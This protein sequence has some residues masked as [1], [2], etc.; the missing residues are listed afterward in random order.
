MDEPKVYIVPSEIV[1][2]PYPYLGFVVGTR[3]Y[4][5]TPCSKRLPI[6]SEGD[7]NSTDRKMDI[8]FDACRDGH[9]DQVE[10]FLE[11]GGNPDDTSQEGWTLLHYAASFGH[12]NIARLVLDRKYHGG[13]DP[14]LK[15]LDDWNALL[16]AASN[17]H[18]EVVQLLLDAGANVN[19]ITSAGTSPLLRAAGRGHDTTIQLLLDAGA[20]P[21]LEG[22]RVNFEYP[23]IQ[24]ETIKTL[25]TNGTY[26][27]IHPWTLDEHWRWPR[28]RR[29]EIVTALAIWR[30]QNNPRGKEG[31]P[32]E[33]LPPVSNPPFFPPELQIRVFELMN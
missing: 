20:D 11:S 7:H 13:A 32:E 23:F 6:S 30:R 15:S 19:V 24:R 16:F 14:D 8:P 12:A 31:K 3:E 18:D 4:P 33:L 28:I 10:Q 22:F 29:L 2:Q 25:L 26:S 1:L 27:W 17:G 9:Y 21:T 5:W